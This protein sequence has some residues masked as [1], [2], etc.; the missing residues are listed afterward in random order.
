M[1]EKTSEEYCLQ[2]NWFPCLFV[3]T[4]FLTLEEFQQNYLFFPPWP[5]NDT[6]WNV[7]KF[8]SYTSAAPCWP[9]SDPFFTFL[10]L[11]LC[12]QHSVQITAWYTQCLCAMWTYEIAFVCLCAVICVVPSYLSATHADDAV[13]AAAGIVEEGHG[14]GVFAGGQPVAFGGRVDLEDMSSGAEDGLLPFKTHHS[15]RE[16]INLISVVIYKTIL[17]IFRQVLCLKANLCR[18][19]YFVQS[20]A[21]HCN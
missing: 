20:G 13:D 1:P 4:F 6:R 9:V 21:P 14:D 11:C 5:E 7:K 10:V 2:I 19:W 3:F 17:C 8:C 15:K 12:E 16:H 18:N